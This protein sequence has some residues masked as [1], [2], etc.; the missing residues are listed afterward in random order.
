M[1]TT[2]VDATVVSRRLKGAGRVVKNLLASFPTVDPDTRYLA[3][4]WPEGASILRAAGLENVVEVRKVTGVSWEMQGLGR[5]ARREGADVVLTL[6]EVVGL[7]GPPT[8][9]HIAEPPAYRLATETTNRP[10]RHVLKDRLLQSTLGGS[11]RRA[12]RVTAASRA[13]ADWLDERYGVTPPV[14]PPGID[15]VFLEPAE[16]APDGDPYFL[17]PA[18][19]DRRDNSALVL[20]AFALIRPQDSRLVL[21]GTSKAERDV[22]AE[23]ARDIGVGDDVEFLGWVSDERLRQL[24]RGAIAL[25]HPSRYEGFAGLQPLEAMAQ[26]T[27]VIALNAPGATEALEDAAELLRTED[28]RELCEAMQRLA[29]DRPYRS[30][31][32]EAGRERVRHL[33][34]RR[35]A[36][37][38]V[39]VFRAI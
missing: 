20:R 28:P 37:R 19:G 8:V 39:E 38:F 31:L 14:I 5:A 11:V 2:V 25:V 15:P 24:Y 16:A 18:T 17:H 4:A 22:L 29:D 7:G 26:G 23:Q 13:T 12:A 34:W 6:R 33:T 27:P 36:E 30:Q 1:R 10:A 32:G 21:I 9:V 3:L 35:A